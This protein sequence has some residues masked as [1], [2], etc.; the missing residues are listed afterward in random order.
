[1][2]ALAASASTSGSGAVARRETSEETGVTAPVTLVALGSVTASGDRKTDRCFTGLVGDDVR[3][4]CASHEVDRAE[5]LTLSVAR[6]RIRHYQK[7]LLDSLV[8]LI[9]SAPAP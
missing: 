8:K 1:M 7:P 5:F 4:V 9:D 2:I 3:P 6:K